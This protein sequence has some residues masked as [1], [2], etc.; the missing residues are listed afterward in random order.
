[1]ADPGSLLQPSWFS[2]PKIPENVQAD[3]PLHRS[4]IIDVSRDMTEL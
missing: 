2:Q 3:D 4:L 1:M